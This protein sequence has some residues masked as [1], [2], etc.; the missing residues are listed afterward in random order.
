[1]ID[2]LDS[3]SCLAKARPSRNILTIPLVWSTGQLGQFCRSPRY[4]C[5]LEVLPSEARAMLR[6]RTG[7]NGRCG[8]KVEISTQWSAGAGSALRMPEESLILHGFAL[9]KTVYIGE[10]HV[11][12][13]NFVVFATALHMPMAQN[14]QNVIFWLR[15]LAFKMLRDLLEVSFSRMA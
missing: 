13:L 3:R 5:D 6:W 9:S 7:R 10:E 15:M 8:R 2:G 12:Y 4:V 1:M 14:C 11:L